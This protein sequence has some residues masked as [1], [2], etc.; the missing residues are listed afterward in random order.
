MLL[1]IDL[2]DYLED[3]E[4]EHTEERDEQMDNSRHGSQGT[5]VPE[6]P[7]SDKNDFQQHFR[8][9]LTDEF[10]SFQES[11]RE[12][13]SRTPKDKEFLSTSLPEALKDLFTV[14]NEYLQLIE[15]FASLYPGHLTTEQLAK[16]HQEVIGA[17]NA[18]LLELTAEHAKAAGQS[19]AARQETGPPLILLSGNAGL[20]PF[21]GNIRT[22]TPCDETLI[23]CSDAKLEKL[24][25]DL[26]GVTGL[27]ARSAQQLFL[28]IDGLLL[29]GIEIVI[30]GINPAAA[31]IFVQL[32]FDFRKIKAFPTLALAMKPK[33]LNVH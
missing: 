30:A 25:I 31:K 2:Q 33:N 15:V 3:A 18:L 27:D 12:W 9:I 7:D 14:Q 8:S 10:D 17:F 29:L 11:F 16:W 21:I 20:L 4:E 23:Q 24:Y 19:M 1:K 5:F 6:P 13:M 28:L 26:S 22:E 32:H